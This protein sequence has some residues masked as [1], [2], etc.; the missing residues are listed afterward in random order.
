MKQWL[1]F[2]RRRF[3]EAEMLYQR[4]RTVNDPALVRS[5]LAVD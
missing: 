3:P 1:N 5:V 2:L 4:L